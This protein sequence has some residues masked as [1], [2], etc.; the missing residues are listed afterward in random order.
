VAAALGTT[1][2]LSG[3]DG[4]LRCVRAAGGWFFSRRQVLEE[5]LEL[6]GIDLLTFV[7]EEAAD[8]VVE[9]LL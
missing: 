8:E 6:G 1:L 7:A 4:L 9:L 2:E 5:E 3:G